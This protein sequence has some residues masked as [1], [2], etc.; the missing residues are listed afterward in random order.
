[1][2][3]LDE[4]LHRP[5]QQPTQE[6]VICRHTTVKVQ[7]DQKKMKAEIIAMECQLSL[8]DADLLVQLPT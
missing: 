1:M 8:S 7:L 6:E 3:I 4:S 5:V 2:P